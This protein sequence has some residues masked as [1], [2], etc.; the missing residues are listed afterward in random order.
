M[1]KNLEAKNLFT[2]SNVHCPE[3]YWV[4]YAML[5][6]MPYISRFLSHFYL[7]MEREIVENTA[8]SIQQIILT[9]IRPLFFQFHGN[10]ES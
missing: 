2:L 8:Q 3:P 1:K 4:L 9:F 7:F 6:V 10:L 5:L